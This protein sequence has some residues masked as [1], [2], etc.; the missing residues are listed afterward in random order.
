MLPLPRCRQAVRAPPAMRIIASASTAFSFAA[1]ALA[2]SAAAT[3][4]LDRWRGDG[5]VVR[6]TG[7]GLMSPAAENRRQRVM[8]PVQEPPGA[9]H[10][11]TMV[12]LSHNWDWAQDGGWKRDDPAQPSVALT[13]E[14][15]FRGLAELNSIWSPRRARRR[16]RRARAR[17]EARQ[18]R[19]ARGR[20]AA[21]WASPR[22]MTAASPSSR[23]AARPIG[24]VLRGSRSPAA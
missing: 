8:F 12:S 18:R 20:A 19:S 16:A 6:G 13:V 5:D 10:V 23:S 14:S 4:V 24:L 21:R 11:N 17:P 15:F 9:P 7:Y 1:F 22:A 3:V 2:L